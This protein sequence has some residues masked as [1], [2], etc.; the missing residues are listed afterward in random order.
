MPAKA[1]KGVRNVS[2]R[3]AQRYA[4]ASRFRAAGKMKGAATWRR[5]EELAL[6]ARPELAPVESLCQPSAGVLWVSPEGRI[7][8]CD[9][10]IGDMLGYQAR[11]LKGQQLAQMLPELAH[12]SLM[13]AG[14]IN[15]RLAFRCRCGVP[16]RA[17]ARNG[18]T[19]PCCVHLNVV[20]T[21]VGCAIA[22]VLAS[23]AL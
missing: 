2:T 20:S 8:D 11:E 5:R 3:G 18:T 15:S 22:V 19:H 6:Q 23:A 12:A 10:R 17:V 13:E 21:D 14:A 1:Q 9:T 16:F 7:L 4:L